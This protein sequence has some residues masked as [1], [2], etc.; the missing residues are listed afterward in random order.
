MLQL[1][2]NI[3]SVNRSISLSLLIHAQDS[4]VSFHSVQDGD[5]FDDFFEVISM[6]ESQVFSTFEADAD[7][8]D[9]SIT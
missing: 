5:F 3:L 7:S 8:H 4:H 6:F 1:G 2:Q 9:L